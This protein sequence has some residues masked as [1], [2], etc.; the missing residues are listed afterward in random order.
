VKWKNN[1]QSEYVND[2]DAVASQ[3]L[4]VE[5]Q[6]NP[7]YSQILRTMVPVLESWRNKLALMNEEWILLW[8]VQGLHN[9]DPVS[10]MLLFHRFAYRGVL[11]FIEVIKDNHEH[12]R[13]AQSS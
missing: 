3:I 8:K 6:H 10:K 1:L 4:S 11:D 7:D 9:S 2:R 5:T 13:G 12:L